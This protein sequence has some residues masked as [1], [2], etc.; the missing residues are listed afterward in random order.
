MT[1]KELVMAVEF[2]ALLPHLKK[3]G[4]RF[5]DSISA[6]REA[7]DRLRRMEPAPGS[8]GT[9]YV[10]Y[11]GYDV[12]GKWIGVDYLD[13]NAWD[14]ELAKEIIVDEDVHLDWEEIAAHCL[15][16]ITFY[17]FSEEERGACFLHTFSKE[18]PRESIIE[19]ITCEGSSFI[20][21]EVSFLLDVQYGIRYDYFSSCEVAQGRLDYILESLTKY[22]RPNLTRYNQAVV[23][24]Y[25]PAKYPLNE[26]EVEKFE[27]V[28]R[29]YLGYDNVMFGRVVR[30]VEQ[31][32]VKVVLL[33]NKCV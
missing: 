15:W 20:R 9:A 5:L 24:V 27:T 8:Q 17:G 7:Y 12:G 3:Y 6:F 18:N 26:S 23:C 4:E 14:V 29:L 13:D 11:H 32:D 30:D 19:D 22:H 21:E 16:E 1:L 33:L 31:E 28:V 25:E 2:D 10:R